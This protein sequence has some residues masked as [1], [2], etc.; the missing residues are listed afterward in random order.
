MTQELKELPAV[1][2]LMQLA[3]EYA[4]RGF[5]MYCSQ[6]SDVDYYRQELQQEIERVVRKRIEAQIEAEVLKD[7]L[8]RLGVETRRKY[9]SV[10]QQALAQ[11]EINR[12][13]FSKAPSKSMCKCLAG[14]NDEIIETIKDLLGKP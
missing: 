4:A 1:T 2:K 13:N 3:D 5:Q 9:N 11:L 14:G 7:K 6:G 8:A 12:T 10:L